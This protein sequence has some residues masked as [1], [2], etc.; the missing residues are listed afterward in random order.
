MYNSISVIY[1][2]NKMK[3]KKAELV[4]K[5][6]E[7]EKSNKDLEQNLQNLKKWNQETLNSNSAICKEL[8]T[9]K[10]NYNALKLDRDQLYATLSNNVDL[11]NYHELK[12]ERDILYNLYEKL[13]A[14]LENISKYKVG[15]T[16]EEVTKDIDYV[17]QDLVD[18][19]DKL[20]EECDNM[21]SKL[22]RVSKAV[23]SHSDD[24]YY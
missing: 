13:K 23:H 12:K 10:T 17:L 21:K 3:L 8:E 7:L 24:D 20:K 22:T 16:P 11:N 14:E 15:D 5:Y 9:L 19:R 18:E 1:Y 2:Y 6:N 4:T